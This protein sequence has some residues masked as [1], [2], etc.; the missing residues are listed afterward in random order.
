M[1]SKASSKADVKLVVEDD[2]SS[3]TATAASTSTDANKRVKSDLPPLIKGCLPTVTAASSDPDCLKQLW[4]MLLEDDELD[5]TYSVTTWRKFLADSEYLVHK[6]GSRLLLEFIET[7][8][9]AAPL[10]R[11]ILGYGDPGVNLAREMFGGPYLGRFLKVDFQGAVFNP[12]TGYDRS[13]RR[14]FQYSSISTESEFKRIGTTASQCSLDIEAGTQPACRL[15][16]LLDKL[17]K[18]C[19]KSLSC[20]SHYPRMLEHARASVALMKKIDKARVEVALYIEV[21]EDVDDGHDES[22][23]AVQL[24]GD[25]KRFPVLRTLT[26]ARGRPGTAAL[27]VAATY[28]KL[29][30][31]KFAS[32]FN[33]F[34]VE[35]NETLDEWFVPVESDYNDQIEIKATL[36]ETLNGIKAEMKPGSIWDI[37]SLYSVFTPWTCSTLSD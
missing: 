20:E 30:G 6:S 37:L 22:Q 15:F 27:D 34:C 25:V 35:N 19:S 29:T 7:I 10:V 18:E 21:E 33:A 3:A 1:D 8:F 5:V 13:N 14:A 16:D 9:T 12:L 11:M 2:S 26:H 4:R 17:T 24:I 31:E 32:G 36:A 28:F 23:F